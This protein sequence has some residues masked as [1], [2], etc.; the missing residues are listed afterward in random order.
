[1]HLPEAI[2]LSNFIVLLRQQL[3][4]RRDLWKWIDDPFQAPETTPPPQM[5]LA[6][7]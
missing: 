7:A 4:V 6:F 5:E 1:M 2:R 3:F